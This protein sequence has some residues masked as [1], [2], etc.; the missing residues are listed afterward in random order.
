MRPD[1]LQANR[2][3][4]NT[5]KMQIKRY[6]P[7]VTPL[8]CPRFVALSKSGGLP[9]RTKFYHRNYAHSAKFELPNG[10]H[11]GTQYMRIIVKHPQAIHF[12]QL[13]L[14]S[15]LKLLANLAIS[16]SYRSSQSN[17]K[18]TLWHWFLPRMLLITCLTRVRFNSN[19][20][21]FPCTWCFHHCYSI[22]YPTYQVCDIY[23]L[24]H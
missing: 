7:T 16:I 15:V 1:A 22:T 2:T 10:G 9:L 14:A 20:N 18:Y 21:A 12:F 8:C 3:Q 4:I 23:N 5:K 24:M 6:P 13:K 17:P 11:R 19:F